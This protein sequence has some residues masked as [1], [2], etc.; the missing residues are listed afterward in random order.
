M[1]TLLN[2]LEIDNINILQVFMSKNDSKYF[3]KHF[4]ST[5]NKKL[6]FRPNLHP[7]ISKNCKEKTDTFRF[8]PS[9]EIKAV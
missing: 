8:S 7:L 4:D 5:V 9:N 6:S 2:S 1:C 3:R